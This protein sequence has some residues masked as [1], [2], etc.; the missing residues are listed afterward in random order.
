MKRFLWKLALQTTVPLL[1]MLVLVNAFLVWK[2]LGLIQQSTGLRVKASEVQAAIATVRIDLQTMET[3]QRGYLLTGDDS[4]LKPYHAAKEGFAHHLADLGGRL[5][6]RDRPLVLQLESI[7]QAQI[8]EMDETIRLREQGYRHRAFLIVG[9]NH[10]Q[11]RMEKAGELLNQLSSAQAG[12]AAGYESQWKESL[13]RTVLQSA[14]ANA[15]LLAVAFVTWFAFSRYR[16]RLELAYAQHDQQ[17]RATS[18]QLGKVTSMMNHDF[19]VLPAEIQQHAD[20][21]LDAYGDYLPP[22]GHQKVQRIRDGAGQMI[23]LLD[24]MSKPAPVSSP[25]PVAVPDVESLSA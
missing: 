13:R 2:N 14:Y 16:T 20:A 6:G 1:G 15:A 4:Y 17:L 12:S 9:S 21:L 8:A 24:G 25:G 3:S 10:G 22:H 11:Q 19:R 7:A 23:G 5:A 18:L